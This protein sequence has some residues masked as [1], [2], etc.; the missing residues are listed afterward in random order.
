MSKKKRVLTNGAV[1]RVCNVS[2]RT[3]QKWFD[4]GLIKGFRLPGGNNRRVSSKEFLQFLNDHNMP[5][6]QFELEFEV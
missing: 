1:A 3:A 2:H 4:V 5:V 6:E